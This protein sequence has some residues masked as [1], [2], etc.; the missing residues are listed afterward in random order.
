[1]V[2]IKKK[3]N[4]SSD[5]R[6]PDTVGKEDPFTSPADPVPDPLVRIFPEISMYLRVSM[7]LHVSLLRFTD[8]VLFT[9]CRFVAT[10]C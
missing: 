9:T 4:Y 5:A 6:T 10:H 8:A 7:H 1:M 3:K 2:H